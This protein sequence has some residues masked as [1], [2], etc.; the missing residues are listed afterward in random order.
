MIN[1]D[2]VKKVSTGLGLTIG[3]WDNLMDFLPKKE[4]DKV[5]KNIEWQ[6]D[7]DVS[8]KRKSYVV[9]I[10]IC[11]NAVDFSV[12]TKEEFIARYGDDRYTTE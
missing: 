10:D 4:L 11:E 8:I 6:T 12:L 3:C 7:T 1:K 2:K 9:E 5:L